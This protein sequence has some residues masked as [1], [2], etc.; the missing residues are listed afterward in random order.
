[1]LIIAHRGASGEF[2]ENSLLA[3]EQAIEQNCDGIELDIQ[4]HQPSKTFI[5]IHDQHIIATTSVK[6]HI[7]D[8]SLAQ[9]IQPPLGDQQPIV[10][11]AQ[12]LKHI[13]GRTLVNIEV[14]SS[15]GT[16]QE[17]TEQI[18]C[19]QQNIQHALIHD[20]FNQAQFI[21]SS[22]NHPFLY[23]CKKAL[24]SIS[25]AAL[26]AHLPL[27]IE[28][29][30]KALDC[31]YLNL[32]VASINQQ[33]VTNAHQLGLKVWVYTVDE[34]YDLALCRQLNVDAVFT[35]FPLNSRTS[36]AIKCQN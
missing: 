17:I 23:A 16:Q 1:M 36:K 31:H 22:F 30:T 26:I 32:D 24:P 14:K 13:A 11:L 28:S 25:T 6:K 8:F 5:V 20:H 29:F 3:F 19:L 18:K 4:F 12:A 33:I 10:T 15:A 2:P 27:E 35:N 34:Y 21:I 9:L 7:N